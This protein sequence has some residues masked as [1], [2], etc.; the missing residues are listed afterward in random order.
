MAEKKHT[1]REKPAICAKNN[2][3]L[4]DTRSLHVRVDAGGDGVEETDDHHLQKCL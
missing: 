2:K 4:A 1:M 3:K